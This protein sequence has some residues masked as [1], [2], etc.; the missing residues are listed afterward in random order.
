MRPLVVLLYILSFWLGV[1]TALTVHRYRHHRRR[2]PM[3]RGTV[4]IRD[5]VVAI[6]MCGL[7]L[8]IVVTLSVG[9]LYVRVK[10]VA[11][12]LQ[13]QVTCQGQ[14]NRALVATLHDRALASRG[15]VL[16]PQEFFHALLPALTSPDATKAQRTHML[17]QLV[18]ANRDAND[19]YDM[20]MA[21]QRNN[22]LPPTPDQFCDS[23][24]TQ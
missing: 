13:A 14:V 9:L 22:P 23:G 3:H 6:A 21:S 11:D 18:S 4:W 1:L 10:N 8:D 16:A 2:I 17:H 20:Y 15:A 12:Q 19:A 7:V 5:H 24:P